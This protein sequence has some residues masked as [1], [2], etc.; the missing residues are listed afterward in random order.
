MNM[1]EPGNDTSNEI[2]QV[3]DYRKEE[4]KEDGIA[5]NLDPTK[6]KEDEQQQTQSEWVRKKLGWHKDY[7]HMSM[8]WTRKIRA[9]KICGPHHSSHNAQ[10]SLNMGLRKKKQQ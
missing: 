10:N 5:N 7:F 8:E 6:E 1:E 3:G 2:I 4:S 9:R